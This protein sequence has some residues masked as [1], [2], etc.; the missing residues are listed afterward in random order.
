MLR[1]KKRPRIGVT[2]PTQ[3]G[4]AAWRFTQLNIL[5]AGGIPLR[6]TPDRKPDI[7]RIDGLVLGGGADVGAGFF[8]GDVSF[9]DVREV[10]RHRSGFMRRLFFA[11]VQG[12]RLL[13]S[14]KV[15]Q[16]HT[17]D[18]ARDDLEM[19]LLQSAFERGIPVLG[20]CRGAQLLNVYCGGTLYRDLKSFYQELPQ[21]R[22]ILPRKEIVLESH[23]KLG[24]I[25]R[26]KKCRVNALHWQAIKQPGKQI[27]VVARERSKVVQAIEHQM[28]PFAIGVQWHPEFLLP[29]RRQRRLFGA[30]INT[31]RATA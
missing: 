15:P 13:G 4:G 22:T 18:K 17:Q 3:G 31:A 7:N 1:L 5:L 10:M 20:I 2:G 29:H 16:R 25:L 26:T 9:E 19:R 27:R 6:I 28:H 23:S 30:L 12:I 8:E 21:I 11:A 24:H 14:Y